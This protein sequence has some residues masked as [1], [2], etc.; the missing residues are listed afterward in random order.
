MS[1]TKKCSKCSTH[2]PLSS[3]SKDSKA[4]DKLN[5]WCR[6]CHN[7]SMRLRRYQLTST[8]FDNLL[9]AQDG[10]CAICLRLFGADERKAVDHDHACCPGEISCG[11]CVR[12][13]THITCN[14]ALGLFGESE[15]TLD[16]TLR[17]LRRH[18]RMR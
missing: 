10:R 18:K 13:L 12:G 7:A 3:F 4:P 14:R 8:Q 6:M 2:L 1:Q 11:E 5:R 9:K 16:N 17:Y 15:E